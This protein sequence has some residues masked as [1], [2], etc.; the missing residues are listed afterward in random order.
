ML[1]FIDFGGVIVG[2]IGA[3]FVMQLP[4]RKWMLRRRLHLHDAANRHSHTL[5][6][7]NTNIHFPDHGKW[8][9]C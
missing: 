6:A 4:E 5:K 1:I 9:F 2:I 8:M 7:V 3:M